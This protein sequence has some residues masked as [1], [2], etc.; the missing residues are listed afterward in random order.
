[1]SSP[2]KN[3]RKKSTGTR[4]TLPKVLVMDIVDV[5][6]ASS[7]KQR[8]YIE[9]I[10][11][12]PRNFTQKHL[13]TICGFFMV[14]DKS[15]WSAHI[16]HFL[17]AEFKKEYF[18]Q[19]KR[20]MS[21]SFIA[22][23]HHT[24]RA[25]A[26]LAKNDNINW[27]GMLDSVLCTYDDTT[28]HFSVTGGGLVLL[29]RDGELIDISEGLSPEQ[30]S[31]NPL[32]TFVDTAS[33]QLIAGDKLILT[34]SELLDLV[35]HEELEKNLTRFDD[36]EFFQFVSTVLTN[37][38][39]MASTQIITI[40]EKQQSD[41]RIIQ[42]SREI[43]SNADFPLSSK[44]AVQEEEIIIPENAFSAQHY[45]TDKKKSHYIPDGSTDIEPSPSVRAKKNPISQK[46]STPTDDVQ[47]DHG[48]EYVDKRT[49]HIYVS[50]DSHEKSSST[51]N[52]H[53][54]NVKDYLSDFFYFLKKWTRSMWQNISHFFS[55]LPAVFGV[56]ADKMKPN[57]K[58]SPADLET[59]TVDEV[60]ADIPEKVSDDTSNIAVDT[61]EKMSSSPA[62]TF[63]ITDFQEKIKKTFLGL[64]APVKNHFRSAS[65]GTSTTT[66]IQKTRMW[67]SSA[68]AKLLSHLPSSWVYTEQIES[69]PI[70]DGV[71]EESPNLSKVSRKKKE[72]P[73]DQDTATSNPSI[74]KKSRA[75][76]VRM[77]A[78]ARS[79]EKN[80]NKAP[81]DDDRF[82]V[83]DELY[84]EEQPIVDFDERDQSPLAKIANFTRSQLS[85]FTPFFQKIRHFLSRIFKQ[86]TADH[87]HTSAASEIDDNL[88]K[89]MGLSAPA[90]KS[91]DKLS[92]KTRTVAGYMQGSGISSI[93]V[94]AILGA[95]LLVS[96]IY[97]FYR[98]IITVNQ[99]EEAAALLEQRTLQENLG[100]TVQEELTI[101]EPTK[102]VPDPSAL[103]EKT[104]ASHSFIFK[105]T[106]YFATDTSLL[107]VGEKNVETIALPKD[108]G[109]IKDIAPIDDLNLIFFLTDSNVLYAYNPSN[110]VF[111]KQTVST[112]LDHNEILTM[113]S[114]QQKFYTATNDGI[115]RFER[116]IGG[117]VSPTE[118]IKDSTAI[119]DLTSLS[120]DG[121]VFVAKDDKI[122]AFEA[123]ILLP[124]SSPENVKARFIYKTQEMQN[125]WV[126]DTANFT[127][128]KL[129][130]QTLRLEE[131]FVHEQLRDVISFSVDESK[132]MAY[133]AG[134]DSVMSLSLVNNIQ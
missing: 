126:L 99:G 11:F 37:E 9:Q 7:A 71:V 36:D 67:L 66:L 134:G 89:D 2:K 74:V 61:S 118:W 110:G 115:T 51:I 31:P 114:Y 73:E 15:S 80:T 1:M 70:D 98:N 4:K 87:R 109:N 129:N 128:H 13:G 113:S 5:F 97:P 19:S 78:V 41:K 40:S 39:Q 63:S 116:S 52:P 54:D 46:K 79:S 43:T 21:E 62:A 47:N 24:N 53:I 111:N 27:I 95:I 100:E 125:L 132:D 28:I 120:V 26:E 50:G 85:R 12:A 131:S 102:T 8:T 112:P 42:K 84:G 65:F 49:G 105:D 88:S 64:V 35:P 81:T 20:S 55:Q 130:P 59:K 57:Q 121:N 34:S 103:L 127:I 48:D 108:S 86:E 82:S 29:M 75:K 56:L 16:V 38:C 77:S 10:N 83:L 96:I 14:R 30:A 123:G 23:L 69:T 91:D 17:N 119:D 90:E 117:F 33:G 76:A 44:D 45:S 6:V 3:T 101:P 94:K 25:L 92:R 18:S 32:K 106:A 104:S 72:K 58:E 122:L 60:V 107:R 68:Y 124:T 133:L 22:A 93:V